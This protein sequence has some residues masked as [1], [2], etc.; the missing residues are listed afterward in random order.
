MRTLSPEGFKLIKR[1][2]RCKLK[3]YHNFPGEPWTIGW[4]NTYYE[5]GAKVKEGDVITQDR[6]DYLY[7]LVVKQFEQAV[8][9]VVTSN[10]TAY[11]FD[12]MVSFAYN[13]GIG[14]LK[15]ST[16]LKKVNA[17]CG[18]PS[19]RD[20]FMKWNKVNK[21]PVDGLTFRRKL[22]ADHYFNS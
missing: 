7:K 19:I 8:S 1:F 5:D 22:E 21:K 12:A 18:D 13:C 15:K 9:E 14:A 20:E 11:Q 10:V 3:A 6:A 2:E 4:G 17:N 16:L